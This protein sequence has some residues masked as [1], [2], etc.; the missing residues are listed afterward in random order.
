MAKRTKRWSRSFGDYGARVRV[1]EER[2]GMLHGQIFDPVLK[3]EGKYAYRRVALGHKDRKEAVKW[4]HIQLTKLEAGVQ[5]GPYR[6]PLVKVVFA[7]YLR[8]RT[9]QKS[10]DRQYTDRRSAEMWTRILGANKDLRKL[11]RREW[12]SFCRDRAS[13]AIDARGNPVAAQDR[14]PVNPR[15]I[16]M[17]AHWIKAVCR[18]ATTWQHDDGSFMLPDDPTRGFDKLTPHEKNPKRPVATYDRYLKIR[19]VTDKVLMEVTWTGKRIPKRSHLSELLD[20]VFFTGRRIS[21]ICQLTHGDLRLGVGPYGAIRWPADSDKMGK[22]WDDTPMEQGA[23]KAIDRIIQ[24][25][26]V[27]SDDTPLFPSPKDRTK[28]VRYELTRV[29][30]QK[31]EALAGVPKQVGGL[32]HPYRRGWAT[33]RKTMSMKDVAALGGWGS[34]AVLRG[35]YQ[36]ADMAGMIEVIEAQAKLRDAR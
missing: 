35:V 23:R 5:E 2:T 18:W 14:R 13:G 24:M 4:A 22:L 28:P 10:D 12:E 17:D 8:Y 11:T 27:V 3:A 7:E 25:R 6:K 21:A 29:W 36:Q 30:L 9:P 20:L 16:E 34:E 15:A 19:A 32:W 26:T 33:A 1:F 31:A